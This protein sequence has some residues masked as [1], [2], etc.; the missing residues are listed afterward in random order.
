M[1]MSFGK[2]P[3]MR[4]LALLPDLCV[5]ARPLAQ[6][7]AIA[8]SLGGCSALD[9][10]SSASY[11]AHPGSS[12][13]YLTNSMPVT[14]RKELLDRYACASEAPLVCECTSR[15]SSTCECRC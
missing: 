1:Q 4:L 11:S 2:E 3:V 13:L 10:F 14:A 9:S 6:I 12:K 15:I 8:L 5:V 7:A